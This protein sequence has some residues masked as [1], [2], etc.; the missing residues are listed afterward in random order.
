MK[1]VAQDSKWKLL[2]K[3]GGIIISQGS[4]KFQDSNNESRR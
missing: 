3:Q 4:S 2:E 1:I